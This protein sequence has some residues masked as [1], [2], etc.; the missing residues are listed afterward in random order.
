MTQRKVHASNLQVKTSQSRVTEATSNEDL[1]ESTQIFMREKK[2]AI[3]QTTRI[4]HPQAD[5][6]E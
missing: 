6:T 3:P 5:T 4:F 2:C 1:L